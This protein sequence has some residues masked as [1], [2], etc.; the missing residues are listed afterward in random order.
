MSAHGG[1][2]AASGALTGCAAA[3]LSQELC[4]VDAPHTLPLEEG[5]QVA[6]RAWWRWDP[7]P[8]EGAAAAAQVRQE[9]TADRRVAWEDVAGDEGVGRGGGDAVRC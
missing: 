3:P 5:Q 6:M 9:R 4:F 7:A 8:E 1:G 2:A